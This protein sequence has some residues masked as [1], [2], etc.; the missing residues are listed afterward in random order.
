MPCARYI[1]MNMSTTAH[2]RLGPGRGRAGGG[3]R[4]RGPRWAEASALKRYT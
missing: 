1:Y 2:W 3:G 4:A